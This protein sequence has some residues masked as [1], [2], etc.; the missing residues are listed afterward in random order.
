MSTLLRLLRTTRISNSNSLQT[1]R[2]S[3]SPPRMS[4]YSSPSHTRLPK[5]RSYHSSFPPRDNSAANKTVLYS[6][7]GIN[8]AVFCGAMYTKAQAQSGYPQPFVKFMRIMT[9]NLTDC[10]KSGAWYQMLTN[11]FTHLDLFHLGG[12]MLTAYFLGGFLCYAPLITPFRFVTIAIGSGITGSVGFLV[13]RY[14]ASGKTGYD[15]VRGL[16][17]SGALMGITSVAACMAPFTKVMIYGIIPVPLWGLVVG[18]GFYDGYYVN[19]RNSRIGHAGHLGG[20]VF[21][22]AYYLLRLRGLRF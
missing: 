7:I 3:R 21:G 19:D 4:N 14:L 22:V 2:T 5:S 6:M 1:L 18:Y 12:N 16:G 8:V 11:T 17:F 13:Q 20:A 9:C 10:L 15:Q